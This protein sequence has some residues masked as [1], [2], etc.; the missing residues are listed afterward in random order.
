M[1]GKRVPFINLQIR[2]MLG[3]AILRVL[4]TIHGRVIVFTLVPGISLLVIGIGLDLVWM[5]A[6]TANVQT[7]G[8]WCALLGLLLG[9][10][11]QKVRASE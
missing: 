4:A 3:A 9:Q 5:V 2:K 10:T 7:F 6:P 8:Y 1:T 11:Y